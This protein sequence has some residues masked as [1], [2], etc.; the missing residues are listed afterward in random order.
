MQTGDDTAVFRP[1]F[2]VDRSGPARVSNRVSSVF[3][4]FSAVLLAAALAV[5]CGGKNK[6]PAGPG[7]GTDRNTT[8]MQSQGADTSGNVKNTG[9]GGN[10]TAGNG[11]STAGGDQAGGDSAAGGDAAGDDGTGEPPAVPKVE[12]PVADISDAEAQKQAASH[13]QAARKALEEKGRNPD[14]AISAA[15]DALSVDPNNVEAVVYL[16]HA[17]YFKKLYST[18]D[19]ILLRALSSPNVRI[20]KKANKNAGVFYVRGLVYD[21]TDEAQKAELAYEKA[22]QLDPNHKGA[23]MNLGVHYIKDS[24]YAD[25]QALFEKLV[26]QLGVRTPAS[27]TDLGSCYRGRSASSSLGKQQRN[28]FLMQAESAYKHAVDMDKNYGPAYYDLGLLYMDASPFP[29]GG[30]NMDELKRMQQAKTYF[31]QYRA[32]PGAELDRVDEMLRKISK[33]IKK[34][35]KRRKNEAKAKNKGNDDW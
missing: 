28:Q 34:E 26:N 32:L 30:Q 12:P 22:H 18:A 29:L 11:G 1:L 15:R 35:E 9:S 31:D 5:G 23:L 20:A 14:A 17:Y 6:G 19:V 4:T 16:A 33:E 21:A 10:Q 27:W 8:G 13:L 24:R 25:A 3:G 2:Q 7:T